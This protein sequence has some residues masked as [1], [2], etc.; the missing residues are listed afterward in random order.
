MTSTDKQLDA[1]LEEVMF[2]VHDDE[3]E[4]IAEAKRAITSLIKELVA[5]AK[6]EIPVAT[7]WQKGIEKKAF[8]DAIR[9]YEYKLLKALEDK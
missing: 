3:W 1:V 6:P 8:E 2:G 5:E 4:A 7:S 9:V